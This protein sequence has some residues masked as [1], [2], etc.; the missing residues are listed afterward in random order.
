MTSYGTIRSVRSTVDARQGKR[1]IR[2]YS[3]ELKEAC[4]RVTPLAK[5]G[6]IYK[7]IYSE[8]LTEL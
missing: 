8:G 7:K 5:N 3:S 1:Y 2:L 4:E 6:K